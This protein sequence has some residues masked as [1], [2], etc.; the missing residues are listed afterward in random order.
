MLAEDRHE[1][2]NESLTKRVLKARVIL[3]SEVVTDRVARRL[4]ERALVMQ[5]DE[6]KKPITVYINSPGGSADSGFA[7]FDI[8][9]F[10]RCPVR[11]VVSGL[12]ASA[13]VLIYV[14]ATRSH[15]FSLPNSR[16]L[17][18]QPSTEIFGAA[19]DIAIDAEEIVKLRERYNQIIAEETGRSL[20]HVT[21]DA[22]RNF[23]LSAPQAV[24]YGLVGKIVKS[25]DELEKTSG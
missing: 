22:D 5:D 19:S 3:V 21:R 13:A 20:E 14:A 7:I 15:R 11:I 18:H 9:R 1:R 25:F 24:E 12:C 17:L 4:I 8:L 16:F 23:W 2:E 10:L 6:P